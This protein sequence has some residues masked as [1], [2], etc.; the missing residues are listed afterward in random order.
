MLYYQCDMRFLS[1]LRS[2]ILGTWIGGIVC[3]GILTAPAIFSKISSRTVAGTVFGEVLRRLNKFELVC[4]ILL[5]LLTVSVRI[6]SSV[7][8][9]KIWKKKALIVSDASLLLMFCFWF[10]YAQIITPEMERLKAAIPSFD[11]TIEQLE[12]DPARSEELIAR[13]RFDFLHKRYS[14][15]MSGNMVLGVVMFFIP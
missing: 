14:R 5:I 13:K 3:A 9:E 15:V 2:L 6:G 10:Y 1:T 7:V 4:I 8:N 12:K 11:V